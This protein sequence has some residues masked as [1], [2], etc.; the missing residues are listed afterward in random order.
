[1]EYKLGLL[2]L[3]AAALAGCHGSEAHGRQVIVL[4]VDGMDPGFLERHWSDLPNVARLRGQGGFRRLG[5]TMPPQSPV[6]WSTF[7]TGLDPAEHGI[8][9]FVHRD[10]RT[11]Q[12]F[13]SMSRTVEPRFQIPLG[14]YVLPLSSARVETLRKGEPFWRMLWDRHIPVTIMHMPTNFPPERVGAAI[15]GM[16]VPDLR[17]TEG[18]FTFYTDDPE[19][20]A[21]D[22]PGGRIVKVAA[23]NGRY[24][25]P[26][27]GP[28]NPL[29]KDRRYATADLVVEADAERDA[30]LLTTGSARAIVQRGEWS[31]WL[32]ADFPL[33]GWLAGARG[34][35]RVYAKEIHPRLE[36]YVTPVNIDPRAPDLPISAP[37]SFSRAVAGAI[38]P[39][40][41]QGI[42]E[43]TSAY[44][45]GV[46]D[47]EEFLRQSTLV[48]DDEMK[49]LRYALDGFREGL[50][51]F[52]FSS[53]DQGSHMLWG[54][55]EPELLE[56]YRAVDA[57]IGEVCRRFPRADIVVMSD[58]GF[59][60]FDRS[61]NLNTWLWEKGFLAL[62]GPPRGD[63]EG[64]ADVDWTKTQA[65]ALG[66]NGLYLNIAGREKNGILRQGA[67]TAAAMQRLARE[68]VE[69]RD[70]ANG[71]Q[72]VETAPATGAP[73][74]PDLIVGYGRGYRGSWE[75]ALGAVPRAILEDNTDV[76]IGDHC[77]NAE[78]VPGVL[79]SN[80]LLRAERPSL[81][82]VTVTILEMFGVG[83]GAGMRGQTVF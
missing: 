30:A 38:G 76:W 79:L 35:F 29:R 23:E 31:E 61:V 33:L 13:S 47:L 7:I 62:Q 27:E 15:S 9:D 42:A 64:F 1:M 22:V 74:G 50:L 25:L 46:L 49:L 34:M 4:G 41:T 6:A 72:V 66:L 2:V 32:R 65:Y 78:D 24:V 68:L 51:F 11:M 20:I 39:F 81:R 18:T 77:I 3:A 59:N 5:T 67:E 26:V 83:A 17:G 54:K 63:D 16:G 8:F 60:S 73:T 19:E 71:R 58:H 12:P 56:I 69:F 36:L 37:A 55:H 28:P 80:R 10:P 75:T 21:R 43:D 53:I 48:R 40:Y 45:Q 57:A 14:P 44:R 52:Y 82:D 70:P